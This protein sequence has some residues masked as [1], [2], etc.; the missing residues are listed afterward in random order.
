M[1]P[2][3][4]LVRIGAGLLQF[5]DQRTGLFGLTT[6]A[7]GAAAITE[8][9]PGKA[10]ARGRIAITRTSTGAAGSISNGRQC[11]Q[12]CCS[13]PKNSVQDFT[14]PVPR[15]RMFYEFFRSSFYDAVRG[16]SKLLR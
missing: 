13:N 1:R 8:L 6:R 15:A 11:H 16:K 9:R 2:L 14:P 4:E 12:Q 3:H 5:L 10:F 7:V